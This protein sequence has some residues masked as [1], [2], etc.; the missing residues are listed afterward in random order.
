MVLEGRIPLNLD[1]LDNESMKGTPLPMDTKD[2]KPLTRMMPL[3][4]DVIDFR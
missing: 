2:A 4:R 1:D 3:S